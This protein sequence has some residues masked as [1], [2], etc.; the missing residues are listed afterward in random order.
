MRYTNPLDEDPLLKELLKQLDRIE[1]RRSFAKWK[2]QFT[3]Q[4]EVHL[5]GAKVKKAGRKYHSF[6]KRLDKNWPCYLKSWK[7]IF[8][9]E[10]VPRNTVPS[11]HDKACPN[12]KRHCLV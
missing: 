1:N 8:A 11:S 9:R 7:D 2:E 12:C 6:A 10:N 3:K 5:E 4:F